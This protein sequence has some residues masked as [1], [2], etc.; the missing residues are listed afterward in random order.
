MNKYEIISIHSPRVGRG[1]S[2]IA[3][4]RARL[5]IS[6]HSPR[7]GRGDRIIDDV[8]DLQYISIHSPR[9]GRGSSRA[10]RS[11][12]SSVFQSTRPGWGEA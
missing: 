6:I 4:F 11:V 5:W 3:E 9:V 1:D 10:S 7:V 2:E 8:A 12:Y